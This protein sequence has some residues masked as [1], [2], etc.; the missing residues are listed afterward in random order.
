MKHIFSDNGT[1][2]IGCA[3]LM[4]E[5][6]KKWNQAQI[7]QSLRQMNIARTSNPPSVSHMG[8]VWERVIRVVRKHCWLLYKNCLGYVVAQ[9][10]QHTGFGRAANT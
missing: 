3:R 5:S 9:L 10:G 8:S 4:Q 6:V 1:N 7:H 2:F